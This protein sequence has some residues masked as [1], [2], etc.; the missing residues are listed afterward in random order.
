MTR[1]ADKTDQMQSNVTISS[2]HVDPEVMARHK[3]R[4]EILNQLAKE[5]LPGPVKSKWALHYKLGMDKAVEDALSVRQEK[6]EKV[7]TQGRFQIQ[8]KT[9]AGNWLIDRSWTYLANPSYRLQEDKRE[10]LD[11]RL[12]VKRQKQKAIQNMALE[13]Q[14]KI[15][16]KKPKRWM[17]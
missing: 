6:A 12:M 9:N 16:V 5:K 4:N 11:M 10:E 13:Q 3:E 2:I 8:A 17:T 1:F 7:K 14:Y 15:V